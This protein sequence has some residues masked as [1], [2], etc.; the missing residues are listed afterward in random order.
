MISHEPRYYGTGPA[1]ASHPP[2]L[3]SSTLAFTATVVFSMCAI[4][5]AASTLSPPASLYAP[6]P[7]PTPA[8]APARTRVPAPT[9]RARPVRAL[10]PQGLDSPFEPS[11][12]VSG[13]LHGGVD[14]DGPR[15]PPG[16]LLGAEA[17][18]LL[19]GFA[20]G[21]LLV[22][23]GAAW[24][25]R[26]LVRSRRTRDAW[27]QYPGLRTDWGLAVSR[28]A[29]WQFPGVRDDWPEDAAAPEGWT[30]VL[31]RDD[32]RAAAPRY[33]VVVVCGP[34]GVG[35]GTVCKRLLQRYP[36]DYAFSVSHTTR[37]PRAGERD[38]RDYHFTARGQ[39]ERMVREGRFVES[40]EFCGNCYGTSWG[41]IEDA[42]RDGGT[43]C[44]LD[45][46]L[47]GAL[48]LREK[49]PGALLLY[50]APPDWEQLEQRLRGRGSE[51]EAQVQ[52]RLEQGKRDVALYQERYRTAFNTVIVLEDDATTEAAELMH[53]IIYGRP[54][55][56]EP[57]EQGIP[58]LL[59]V[60][61]V[62]GK[63]R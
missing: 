59:A 31:Q 8:A 12:R 16:S 32:A 11:S 56:P 50:V 39:F 23:V 22:Y 52:A 47:Q 46:D 27:W 3:C 7:R 60:A 51:E 24:L 40:T 62:S 28:D 35:K 4:A 44:L 1:D 38:G 63:R 9:L 19:L 2:T 61:L 30:G 53:G 57:L 10:P 29:W 49:I 25:S 48:R 21:L 14:A 34:S 15:E 33:P 5:L 58:T 55:T 37:A 26:K 36:A 45:L 42:S 6:P 43:C 17:L 13:A 54:G 20:L 41:A 18:L